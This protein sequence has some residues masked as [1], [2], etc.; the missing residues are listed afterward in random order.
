MH[1][2]ARI[3]ELRL[4]GNMLW[5][6]MRSNTHTKDV[7]TEV[8]IYFTSGSQCMIT[9][10]CVCLEMLISCDFFHGEWKPVYGHGSW[11][12]TVHCVCFKMLVHI[13]LRV[14]PLLNISC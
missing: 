5:S 3:S 10:H 9:G 7:C 6:R 4:L 12:L 11:S 8:V 13:L 2:A 14:V 1:S